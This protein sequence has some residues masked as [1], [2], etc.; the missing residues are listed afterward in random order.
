MSAAELQRAASLKR[1]TFRLKCCQSII[2]IEEPELP[3]RQSPRI[4]PSGQQTRTGP[5]GM[6]F[7]E[8]PLNHLVGAC[9][10]PIDLA[11]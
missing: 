7:F 11:A 5:M 2:H 10:Q 4:M 9:K 3:H 6:L 8:V 1:I